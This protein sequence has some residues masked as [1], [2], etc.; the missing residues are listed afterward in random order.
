MERRVTETPQSERTDKD[1]ERER[2]RERASERDGGNGKKKK[3]K[4][5]CVSCLPRCDV[6]DCLLAIGL[7]L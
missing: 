4:L 5:C 3:K 6:R 1:V 2:E 7:R